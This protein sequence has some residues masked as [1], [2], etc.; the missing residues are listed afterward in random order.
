M[1]YIKLNNKNNNIN[2]KGADICFKQIT[3]LTSYL[4]GSLCASSHICKLSP[5]YIKVAA[6]YFLWCPFK[7]FLSIPRLTCF[8]QSPLMHHLCS[9]SLDLS[10]LPASVLVPQPDNIYL[11]ESSWINLM[12]V[13]KCWPCWY[14]LVA[15][16]SKHKHTSVILFTVAIFF[17]LVTIYGSYAVYSYHCYD[18][19]TYTVQSL[20]IT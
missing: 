6:N 10:L 15:M 13:Q 17:S 19:A 7:Y 1:Y 3:L 12:H 20:F 14:H 5:Y 4:K 2:Q 8:N 16:V 9:G 11:L 18:P